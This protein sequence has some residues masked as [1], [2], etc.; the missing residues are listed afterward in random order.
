MPEDIANWL[1]ELGLGEY[2]NSFEEGAIDWQV[3]P[4][5]DHEIL[6]ELGVK[7]GHR[8]RILNA[9]TDLVRRDTV[10]RRRPYVATARRTV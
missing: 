5:L 6:K 4:S 2:A 7:P 9:V 8:L 3:L 1:E 10:R